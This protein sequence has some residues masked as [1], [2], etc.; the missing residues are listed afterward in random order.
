[1]STGAQVAVLPT[2]GRARVQPESGAAERPW[3]RLAAFATLGLYGVLRWAT[4][5]TPPAIWR[6]LGLLAVAVLV[7]GV[8]SAIAERSRLAAAA[9]GVVALVAMLPIAGVPLSL[10]VH[11]RLAVTADRIG[12]GLS[13]LPG[14][15]VPYI[16]HSAWV[17]VVNLLGAGVLLLDAALVLALTPPAL[18]DLRRAGAALPLVALVVVPSTLTQPGS[19][20]LQGVL[21]FALL[22]ALIWGERLAN[23]PLGAVSLIAGLA[24]LAA[25]AVAP[26]LNNHTPWLNYEALGGGAL[27]HVEEF[28]WTQTYGPLDWPRSGHEVLDVEAQHPDYWKAE[29]LDEFNGYQWTA[30][31]LDDQN[32]PGPSPSALNRW[33][34]TIKVTL[35]GISTDNVIAAGTTISYPTSLS[36]TVIAGPSPGTWSTIDNLGPGDSYEVQVYSPHPSAA[37]LAYDPTAQAGQLAGDRS[38]LLPATGF[39]PSQEIAFAPFHGGGPFDLTDGVGG[40]AAVAELMR[41]PYRDA[42]ALARELAARARTPY[43]FVQS[44]LSYLGHGYA[45]YERP[46]A[47]EYPV[48]SFLFR[49]KAGYCQQ[50]SGA[51]ALLLRMGGVPAQVAAGFTTGT[52]QPRSDEYVVTDVDAHDWVEVWF[53]GYG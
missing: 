10:I 12:H 9:L 4:L 48:E 21:L 16:G 44:V 53:L 42:Y 35:R 11:V 41:S 43:A 46:P 36:E 47:R 19:V 7:A 40:R 13:A 8:G 28:N 18:G 15:L 39:G 33:S 50:F 30:A 26:T 14:S 24:A 51:M 25:V 29:N 27:A 32:A 31:P 37:E 2:G 45:Y 38:I 17:R 5:L 34:Q 6:L 1:V 23:R 20:Y 49:D 52:P 22:V 3:L